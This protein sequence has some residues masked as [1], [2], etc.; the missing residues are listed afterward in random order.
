MLFIFVWMSDICQVHINQCTWICLSLLAAAPLAPT[1]VN[2]SN[3]SNGF[4]VHWKQPEDNIRRGI[5]SLFYQIMVEGE[6]GKCDNLGIVKSQT[7]YISCNGW[8]KNKPRVCTVTV[9]T[10]VQSCN[11]TSSDLL[12]VTVLNSGGRDS[13]TSYWIMVISAVIIINQFVYLLF[14]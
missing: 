12:I 13:K 3:D 9:A 10:V 4:T 6:C 14:N 8:G 5:D 1:Y 11:F 7:D 2:S